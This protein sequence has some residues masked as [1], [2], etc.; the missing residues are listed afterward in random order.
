[1]TLAADLSGN[2]QTRSAAC[3]AGKPALAAGAREGRRQAG[4]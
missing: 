2:P 1:M 3:R 4:I